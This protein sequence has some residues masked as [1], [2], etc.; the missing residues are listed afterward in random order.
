MKKKVPAISENDILTI[1]RS[2]V[3]WVS[4]TWV[5]S[6]VSLVSETWVTSL[7]DISIVSSDIEINFNVTR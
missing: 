1:S 6:F 2:C 3:S 7:S 4:E 5:T